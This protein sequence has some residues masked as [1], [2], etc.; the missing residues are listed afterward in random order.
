LLTVDDTYAHLRERAPDGASPHDPARMIGNG[1]VEA[2]NV[3]DI[4]LHWQQMLVLCSDGLHK[5]VDAA[6]IASSRRARTVAATTRR[7][8]SCD[9][10]SASAPPPRKVVEP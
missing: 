6:G 10:A 7:F 5:H 1:A 3:R 9:D 8:S 4:E 2:P